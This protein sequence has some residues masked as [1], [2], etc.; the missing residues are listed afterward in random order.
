MGRIL[1]ASIMLCHS[2]NG[3]TPREFREKL[4]SHSL[5]S[6]CRQAVVRLSFGQQL[7]CSPPQAG[8]AQSGDRLGYG[9]GDEKGRPNGG[10]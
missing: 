3:F 7:R 4:P 5:S 6:G 1:S 9:W 8:D 10:V 2:V